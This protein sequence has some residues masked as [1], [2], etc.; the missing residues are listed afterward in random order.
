MSFVILKNKFVEYCRVEKNFSEH[1]I[2]GYVRAL[3]DFYNYF[4]EC[5]ETEPDV[6]AIESDDIKT[7][8][9]WLHDNGLNKNSIR[10]KVSAV[11][12][13]FKFCKRK[14]IIDFNPANMLATPK[15]ERRLPSFLTKDETNKLFKDIE[16]QASKSSRDKCLIELLYSS[17]LRLSEALNL[18]VKDVDLSAKQVKVL[19]KGRKER[20]VPVGAKAIN[21]IRQYLEEKRADG[22]SYE[23]LFTSKS[24]TKLNP[25][26]AY[27]M[28]RKNIGNISDIKRKSPHS[29]RH[30]FATHLLDSGAD[31]KSVSEMLGHKS[32]ST[33]QVYTHLSIERLKNA[34][35]MAHPKAK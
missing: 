13:F 19:G 8:L 1:T 16:D 9:G 23:L 31:I 11:K 25:S 32:L 21:A 34:Y 2:T 17:G 28:V 14:K 33:T 22:E 29:L 18:K 7:F 6:L 30:T 35:T 12:S 4:F 5:Y 10:L 27:R 20:I 26:V 3:D 15:R 24:G